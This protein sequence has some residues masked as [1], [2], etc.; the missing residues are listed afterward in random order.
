MTQ[1]K[2]AGP[3]AWDNK[4]TEEWRA[5]VNAWSWVG[6]ST[7][8]WHKHGDCPRCGHPMDVADSGFTISE[9]TVEVE[10]EPV[11]ARCDCTEDHPGG[12]AALKQGCGQTGDIDP[13]VKA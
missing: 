5:A 13:P 6:D 1:N 9:Y 7:D 3:L 8:D 11:H 2:P 4:P 10:P 12:P